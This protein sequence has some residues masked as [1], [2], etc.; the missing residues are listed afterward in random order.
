[1]IGYDTLSILLP[2]PSDCINK[3]IRLMVTKK[4]CDEKII[5]DQF[6]YSKY[7]TQKYF[8]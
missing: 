1:M 7:K 8:S 6:M 3:W 4:K 2:S 5:K